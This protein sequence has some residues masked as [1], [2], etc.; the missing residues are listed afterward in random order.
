MTSF[1]IYKLGK[2]SDAYQI[3]S[4][5]SQTFDVFAQINLTSPKFGMNEYKTF[6]LLAGNICAELGKLLCHSH[7]IWNCC[8]WA[9]FLGGLVAWGMEAFLGW[10]FGG[11]DFFLWISEYGYFLWRCWNCF[12]WSLQFFVGFEYFSANYLSDLDILVLFWG[13]KKHLFNLISIQLTPKIK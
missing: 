4:N 9:S 10:W 5:F 11:L 13:W 12:C 7:L 2:Y 3:V 6:Y 1:I 8:G